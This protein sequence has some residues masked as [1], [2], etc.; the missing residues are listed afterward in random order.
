MR[1]ADVIL[2]VPRATNRGHPPYIAAK[3]EL[4]LKLEH[5]KE[6]LGIAVPNHEIPLHPAA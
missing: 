3:T 6:G 4:L 5:S 2:D 1:S